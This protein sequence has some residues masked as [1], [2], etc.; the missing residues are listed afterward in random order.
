MTNQ[1]SSSGKEEDNNDP[2]A[3]PSLWREILAIVAGAIIDVGSLIATGIVIVVFL[4]SQPAFQ[5]LLLGPSPEQ[6]QSQFISAGIA[7]I[8]SPVVITLMSLIYVIGGFIAGIIAR[9]N[10]VV[11]GLGSGVLS[12]VIS[13]ASVGSLFTIPSPTAPMTSK[14][15]GLGYLLASGLGGYLAYLVRVRSSTKG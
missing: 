8:N 10:E 4:L 3:K 12:S 1:F 6:L 15:L 9:R 11:N 14:I 13:L 2:K 7:L 5:Q